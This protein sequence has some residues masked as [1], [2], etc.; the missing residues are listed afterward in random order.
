VEQTS[1]A[2]VSGRTTP[3]DLHRED[4]KRML[5]LATGADDALRSAF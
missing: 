3:P 4:A 1:S 5:A 2:K